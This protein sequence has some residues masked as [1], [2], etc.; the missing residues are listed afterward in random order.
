MRIFLD[1]G[2]HIGETLQ[3][4]QDPKWGFDRVV[5]FEPAPS[6]WPVLEKMASDRTEI[7]RF[8]LWR[9]D[10]RVT[11]YNAGDV[12]ASVY[13]DKDPELADAA[14]CQFRDA[15]VW[16]SENVRP[17]DDVYAKINVEG[18]E[19]ELIG[20][21]AETGTLSLID[22]LVDPLRRSEGSIEAPFGGAGAS[23]TRRCG[24]GLQYC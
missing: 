10:S 23:A 14:E 2:A 22:H 20:R 19:A 3:V 11:L 5:S 9:E 4:A 1:I 13:A 21:L 7:C 6:C 8:G 18:A 15:F 16:L 24:G 17:D 12:G